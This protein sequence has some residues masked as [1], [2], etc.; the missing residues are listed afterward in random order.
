MPSPTPLTIAVPASMSNLGPGFD[1]AGL[2]LQLV[3]RFHLT[4]AHTTTITRH[5][6]TC[7]DFPEALDTNDNLISKGMQAVWQ[8][9]NTVPVTFHCQVEAHIPLARGL[10]S[11]STAIIAGLLAANHWAGSPLSTQQ[12]VQL[13]TKLEGHPDNAA[14]ALL[15]G[16]VWC[17]TT[18]DDQVTATPL[19]WPTDWAL[20]AVIPNE[21]LT[22][23]KARN[24]LPKEFPIATSIHTLR[25]AGQWVHAIHTNDADLFKQSLNDTLHQPYRG[26]LIALYNPV[27]AWANQQIGV[28]GGFISGAGSTLGLVCHKAQQQQVISDAKQWLSTTHPNHSA[29][30]IPVSINN[31]GATITPLR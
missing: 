9:T 21:P 10:G 12:L 28:I 22:T 19:P 13:A 23:E 17:D 2:A 24:A 1:T 30:I 18:N 20:I 29:K 8:A 25:K 16:I 14:P 27:M 5:S 7:V 6:G 11:S 4:P 3:N 26:P 15:G 31:T